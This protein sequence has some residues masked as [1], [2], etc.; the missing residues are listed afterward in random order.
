MET[1]RPEGDF[2]EEEII[3]FKTD[4][5]GVFPLNLVINQAT[6]ERLSEK[7]VPPIS[8]FDPALLLCWFIPRKVVVK[9]TKKGKTYWIVE[10]IDSNNQLTKIRCWGIRPE[11]DRIYL[12]R[13]YM[14]KLK[15]DEQWGFSTVEKCDKCGQEL[16]AKDELKDWSNY[17]KQIVAEYIKAQGYE[18]IDIEMENDSESAEVSV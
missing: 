12:N 15:H 13:P 14:A 2:T 5:T 4:L 6:I 10:T 8:E 7:G 16:P 18:R 11:K 3:Q 1:Y 9:K 17:N